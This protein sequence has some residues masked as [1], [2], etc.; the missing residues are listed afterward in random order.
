MNRYKIS[1][2]LKSLVA[3]LRAE[4]A[5]FSRTAAEVDAAAKGSI[6]PISLDRGALYGV[7]IRLG[8][9]GR[10]DLVHRLEQLLDDMAPNAD[11]LSNSRYNR[12]YD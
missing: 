8:N 2:R 11:L 12:D 3:D 1:E 4:A 6:I 7:A 10:N 5:F 9:A